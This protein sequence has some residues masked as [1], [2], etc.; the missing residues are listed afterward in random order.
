MRL[1]KIFVLSFPHPGLD[2][3]PYQFRKCNRGFQEVLRILRRF[4]GGVQEVRHSESLPAAS[5]HGAR[6]CAVVFPLRGLRHVK[7]YDTESQLSE[8]PHQTINIAPFSI[9]T[10]D[11]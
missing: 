8:A 2:H 5:Q 7:H 10:S 11:C 4:S 1:V 3:L 6:D 9:S